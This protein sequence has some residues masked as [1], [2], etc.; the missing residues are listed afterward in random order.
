MS[1]LQISLAIA[2]GVVLAAVIG[3]GTWSARR[4]APKRAQLQPSNQDPTLEGVARSFDAD[5]PA[6]REP[7]LDASAANMSAPEKKPGLD[8]L[9]DVIVP[10]Q[11]ESPVSAE[12]IV[13]AMPSTR[14]VGSKPFALEGLNTQTGQWEVPVSGQRYSALQAG[15]QLANRTGALNQIEYS[16]FVIKTRAVADALGGEPEFAEMQNE[17]A[18]AKELDQFAGGHDAQLTFTLR[19]KQT[20]WSPGYVQQSASKLGF[21]PGLIPG[22]MVLPST[23][24]APMVVLTFDTQAALAE[25]PEQT[26][27]HELVLFLDVP[28][29]PRTEKPF[30]RMC[31]IAISL[32]SEMEGVIVDEGGQAIRAQTMEDIAADLERLYDTLDQ[33][34][35]SAGSVLARRLFS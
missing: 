28:Q 34:D 8:A 7:V 32:A 17:V 5:A 20:A 23:A 2:G 11:I 35:L 26:A 31:E 4:N 9:I 25:D 14:R 30:A 19:A 27:L 21:V 1:T 12:A 29:V 24:S 6:R 18:R 10:I 3:H 22:R 13:A 33:R 15:I 16:E